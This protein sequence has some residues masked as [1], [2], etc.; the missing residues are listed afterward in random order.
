M[1]GQ[2]NEG[3][4]EK[5]RLRGEKANQIALYP[6]IY[7]S[8]DTKPRHS[9]WCHDVLADCACHG[10]P[11]RGSNSS[12]LSHKQILIAN[13][14][15]EP[16]HPNRQVRGRTARA[17][18]N[19]NCIGRAKVSINWTPESWHGLNH[20]PKGI[21]GQVLGPHY[22]CNRVLNCQGSVGGDILSPVETWYPRE[23]EC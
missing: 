20:Q 13:H 8:T 6:G 10:G 2:K 4:T 23:V 15:T 17:P 7:P 22:I 19:C 16:S 14:W 21:A 5:E 3:G 9:C 1:Q 11:M 12:F 18:W